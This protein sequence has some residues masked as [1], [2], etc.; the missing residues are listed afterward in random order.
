VQYRQQ[1]NATS[2]FAAVFLA[3]LN[4][5]LVR[6][7]SRRFGN[8]F[9]ANA[10]AV[11]VDPD[12][13]VVITGQVRGAVDYSGGEG[14]GIV[15]GGYF[16]SYIA[17]YTSANTYLK[18]V[19]IGFSGGGTSTGNAIKCL[20]DNDIVVAG[21]FTFGV[22]FGKPT[23][24]PTIVTS[25]GSTDIFIGRYK[26]STLAYASLYQYGSTG[27]DF[28]FGLAVVSAT[29]VVATGGFVGTVNFGTE[30]SPAPLT[31]AGLTDAFLLSLSPSG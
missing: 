9:A 19:A 12:D 3:K 1:L 24:P 6:L 22:D 23:T 10:Y 7:A 18:A 28:C 21:S 31:S 20:A 25:A 27:A 5:S 15:G 16:H 13:N 8:E 30:A 17:R 26:A 29:S 4:T 14:G 11:A 2:E